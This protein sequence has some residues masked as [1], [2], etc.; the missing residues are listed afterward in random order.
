MCVVAWLLSLSFARARLN[1]S[2]RA[3]LG[4]PVL[5]PASGATELLLPQPPRRTIEECA[6]L[7]FPR[8]RRAPSA[9]GPVRSAGTS[10]PDRFRARRQSSV[11]IKRRTPPP[12]GGRALWTMLRWYTAQRWPASWSWSVR[13]DWAARRRSARKTEDFRVSRPRK[14]DE[15]RIADVAPEREMAIHQPCGACG[16]LPAEIK[17]SLLVTRL[18]R[19][20][21]RSWGK[22]GAPC[23]RSWT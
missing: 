14:V 21:T 16:A 11:W 9:I 15:G 23:C 19:A 8:S 18:R 13:A 4:D 10:D 2:F 20:S 5:A 22:F 12:R 17:V 1:N 6:H 7:G 3:L